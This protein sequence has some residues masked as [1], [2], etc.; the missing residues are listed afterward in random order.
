M[1]TITAAIL[2]GG[3]ASRIKKFKPNLE[4]NGTSIIENTILILK[5]FFNKIVISSNEPF[6]F[7]KFNLPVIEDEIKDKDIFGGIYSILK[8]IDTKYAFIVPCD[9]P[10]INEKLIEVLLNSDFN[11]YDITIFSINGKFQPLFAIYSKNCLNFF[12]ETIKLNHRPKVIEILNR[13]K[14]LIM[15]ESDIPFKINFQ[16]AFFNI[17]TESDYYRA[18]NNI[19]N[20]TKIFGIV[21]KYS[22]SGKTTLIERLIEE[23]KKDSFKVGVLKHSVHKIEIDKP[24][25][26]TYRFFQKGADS[27]LIDNEEQLFFRKKLKKPLP[28]KYLKDF[29]FNDVDILIVEGH[30]GGNFPKIELIKN[31]QND[32][33]FNEDSNIIAI[34]TDKKLKSNIPI[35]QIDNISQIY[36][37]IKAKLKL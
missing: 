29:Y 11:K 23:F 14:T 15:T 12:K 36:N 18:K 1:E 35:F 21:A 5:K 7:E 28:V 10:F 3:K 26:D 2:C 16:K 17:N 19:F 9:M 30:K 34:V 33:L 13:Y 4:I 27:I 20:E 37:F 8:K 25:K 32:Y 6:L 31:E 22:N 24:G